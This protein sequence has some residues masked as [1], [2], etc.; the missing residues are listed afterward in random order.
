M[1]PTNI[2]ERL[3]P[4]HHDLIR[5]RKR[6][7]E[8]FD[9]ARHRLN[10]VALG[11]GI[12]EAKRLKD[13]PTL[14]DAVDAK[15]NE[16]TKFFAWWNG[17]VVH[18]GGSKNRVRGSYSLHEAEALTGMRQQRVSDLG[19]KLANPEKYRAQLLGSAY[20]AA[21]LEA[22]ENVRGTLGTGENEWFTPPQYIELARR[23][24]G[25]ID[26][27]P[28]SREQAQ[29]TI[30]AASYFTKEQDGLAQ[31]WRGNIWINPPYSRP[32]I[33]RFVDKLCDEW[34]DRPSHRRDHADAQLQRHDV[35]PARSECLRRH[36]LYPW[37]HQVHRA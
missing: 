12:E 31:D 13:W 35:V 9:P 26:L 30:A 27:D 28:A 14:L 37:P 25:R 11:Y 36:L 24:L 7:V 29:Q 16:Q 10:D 2:D 23:V 4:D 18:G 32:L 22:A 34:E 17:A 3:V 33:A 6:D 21:M 20:R 5:P 19:K 15:I 1:T 8:A